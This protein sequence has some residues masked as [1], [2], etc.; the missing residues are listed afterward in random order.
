MFG[1]LSKTRFEKINKIFSN[2]EVLRTI[3]DTITVGLVALDFAALKR[4]IS[5]KLA[6]SQNSNTVNNTGKTESN[7]ASKTDNGGTN[8]TGTFSNATNNTMSNSYGD[9]DSASLKIG[10]TIGAD[11]DITYGYRNSYDAL[12]GKNAVKLNQ[13]IMKDNSVASAVYYPNSQ[14]IMENLNLEK[15]ANIVE[16]LEKRGYD[17]SKAVINTTNKAGKAR[18]FTKMA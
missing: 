15:G 7:L 2:K 14:G 1:K 4:V 10:D 18:A 9:P 3:A 12:Y 8:T 11:G 6:A 5:K 16:E 17:I 13:A